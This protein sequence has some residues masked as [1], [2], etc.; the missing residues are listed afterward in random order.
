MDLYFLWLNLDNKIENSYKAIIGK[1]N[2]TCEIT[3]G[4]VNITATTKEINI[5]YFLLFAKSW[6]VTIPLLVKSNNKTGNSKQIPKANINFIT[7]DKYSEILGSNSI[8]KDPF[9]ALIWK[10]IKKSHAN[11]ITT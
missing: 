4:G 7:N 5:A 1:A 2:K 6:G 3:S 10:D 11:G 9:I 8:G